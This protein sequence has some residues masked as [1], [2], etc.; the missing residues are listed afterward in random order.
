MSSLLSLHRPSS[1]A[2]NSVNTSSAPTHALELA[3]AL[4]FRNGLGHSLYA[5]T[6]TAGDITTTEDVQDLHAH[7]VGNPVAVLSTG[8]STES[9]AKLFE[10]SFSAHK[11][12]GSTTYGYGS[13]AGSHPSS[14]SKWAIAFLPFASSA[15]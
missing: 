6:H 9:L 1:L 2:T 14:P 4:A 7:A 8:I 12:F 11:K 15:K 10:S 3:H 13:S 5:D